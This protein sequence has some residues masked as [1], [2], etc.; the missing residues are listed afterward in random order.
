M[1]TID[2][3]GIEMYFEERGAGEPLVLLHGFTGAGADWAHVYDLDELARRYQLVVP[4]LRGHGRSTNPAGTFT[5][6]QCAQ[7]V[8]ALLDHL[9]IGR[10]RAVGMSL[11]GNTLLHLA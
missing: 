10:C 6:A 1:T 5:H 8:V 11:G 4:D 2:I 7:D 3:N 9:G